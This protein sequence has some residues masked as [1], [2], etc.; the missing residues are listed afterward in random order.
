MSFNDVVAADNSKTSLMAANFDPF[1]GA[2]SPTADSYSPEL[3]NSSQYSLLLSGN[4]CC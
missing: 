2:M 3:R 4:E 1:T